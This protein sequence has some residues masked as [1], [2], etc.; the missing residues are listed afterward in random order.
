MPDYT[1][2][3]EPDCIPMCRDCRRNPKYHGTLPYQS[4]SMPDRIEAHCNSYKPPKD[5]PVEAK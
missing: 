5:K 3:G 1:L 2:C 4:Y